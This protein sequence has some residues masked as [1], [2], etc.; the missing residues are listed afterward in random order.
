MKR[1]KSRLFISSPTHQKFVYFR[2]EM[3]RGEQLRA[4]LIDAASE[5]DESFRI[6]TAANE[7]KG[8]P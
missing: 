3:R 2:Q 6:G 4:A 1:Q 5:E 7:S 8:K